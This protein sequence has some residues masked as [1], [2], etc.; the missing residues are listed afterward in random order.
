[1]K[2]DI[3]LW[4]SGL[5]GSFR[6]SGD[7]MVGRGNL[8]KPHSTEV[9]VFRWDSASIPTLFPGGDWTLPHA[10]PPPWLSPPPPLWPLL[11][12]NKARGDLAWGVSQD[13]EGDFAQKAG[14][15][16]KKYRV[17]CSQEFFSLL[18]FGGVEQ[19]Q[20]GSPWGPS[21]RQPHISSWLVGGRARVRTGQRSWLEGGPGR[22]LI[23]GQL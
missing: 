15:P 20:L 4:E 14:C 3:C 16:G 21:G 19:G 5:E 12:L 1:M 2:L 18:F 8:E 11:F 9:L 22:F 17:N 6:L 7:F 23:N 13:S 10:P